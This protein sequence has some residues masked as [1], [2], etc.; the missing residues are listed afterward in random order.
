MEVHSQSWM[1]EVQ[2]GVSKFRDGGIGGDWFDV[3]IIESF[4]SSGKRMSK[5]TIS[6][7]GIS[8]DNITFTNYLIISR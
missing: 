2:S 4:V 3:E 5:E 8:L 7:L 1:V 6:I